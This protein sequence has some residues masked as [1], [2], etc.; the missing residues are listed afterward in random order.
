MQSI[1]DVQYGDIVCPYCC[2]AFIAGLFYELC[3][4]HKVVD[5]VINTFSVVLRCPVQE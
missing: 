4:F 5:F 1:Y 3:K 2:F